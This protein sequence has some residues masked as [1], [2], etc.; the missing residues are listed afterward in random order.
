MSLKT[1]RD[2]GENLQAS[3]SHLYAN[4]TKIRRAADVIKEGP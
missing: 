1:F 3:K 2:E 4:P